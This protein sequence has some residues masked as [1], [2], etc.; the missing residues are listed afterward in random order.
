MSTAKKLF[1]KPKKEL[2]IPQAMFLDNP[3][4]GD[5]EIRLLYARIET[6]KEG[7]EKAMSPGDIKNGFSPDYIVLMMT[8]QLVQFMKA[9]L[10]ITPESGTWVDRLGVERPRYMLRD[11]ISHLSNQIKRMEKTRQQKHAPPSGGD[12]KN[13]RQGGGA[14]ERLQ[15]ASEIR[16]SIYLIRAQLKEIR[17]IAK[18][19]VT[20]LEKAQAGLLDDVD[21]NQMTLFEL[22]TISQEVQDILDDPAI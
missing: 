19:K 13:E 17:K 2:G 21:D 4:G 6:L 22:P 15:K 7:G 14:L 12:D 20:T 3:E 9:R 8:R 11:E 16:R 5:L 18:D 1:G 10:Q